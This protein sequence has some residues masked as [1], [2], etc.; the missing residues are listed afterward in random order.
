MVE[1]KWLAGAA[2]VAMVFVAEPALAAD[3]DA[4]GAQGVKVGTVQ[5]LGSGDKGVFTLDLKAGEGVWIQLD[6]TMP[7]PQDGDSGDQPASRPTGL[8]ICD[9]TGKQLA[10]RASDVFVSGGS[11][12]RTSEGA[13]RLAFLP[14]AAGSYTI[15]ADAVDDT[16]ELLVRNRDVPEN[17]GGPTHLE[18]GGSDFAKVSSTKPLIYAVQGKAGQWVKITATSDAD[19]VLH[20]AAPLADGYS[21]IADNDDSD[22]L[23]P[24]IVRKLPVTGTYYVQVESLTDDPNDVSVLIEPTEAPPPPPPPAPLKAGQTVKGTLADADARNLYRLPVTAGHTYTLKVDAP[25]D[26]VL[27]VGLPDPLEADGDDDTANGFASLRSVDDGTSGEETLTV[28]AKTTGALLVQVRSFGID[29]GA[30]YTLS[31]TEAGG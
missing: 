6:P 15:V 25:F 13:L 26:A 22:G 30:D 31:A 3:C 20:L 17:A 8:K 24:K 28:T 19:T 29:E 11:L 14:P 4:T 2:L 21:V 16:R 5:P 1:F 27:D 7:T 9:A 18:M 12:S 10:P 23:N